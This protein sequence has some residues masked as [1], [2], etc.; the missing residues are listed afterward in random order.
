MMI[1]NRNK[2]NDYKDVTNEENLK[3]CNEFK[4][5]EKI[6]PLEL[7]KKWGDADYDSFL[8]FYYQMLSDYQMLDKINKTINDLQKGL[9]SG[10]SNEQKACDAKTA[11]YKTNVA[12]AIH[13]YNEPSWGID[14]VLEYNI[15]KKTV[16]DKLY[17]SID[18]MLLR[19]LFIYYFK[20]CTMN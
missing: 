10:Q 20:I 5:M 7:F 11:A 4:Y 17:T 1:I 6:A 19:E 15:I 13:P 16:Q 14:R 9:K 8:S 2:H 18:K 12:K 3:F